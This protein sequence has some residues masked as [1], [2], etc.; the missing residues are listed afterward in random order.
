MDFKEAIIKELKKHVK[1]AEIIINAP[2]EPSMG[3]FAFPCFSLAKEMKKSPVEIAAELKEKIKMP[4]GISEVKAN[5]PY[6]NFFVK[7]EE[8]AKDVIHE[9]LK[10]KD[11]YGASK[12]KKGRVMVEFFHANTHK[13]VHIG[14]IRNISLGES[15]CRIMELN[16]YKVIRANY[17]GDIGPHV[18]KCLWGLRNSRK[19]APAGDKMSFL[20]KV[21]MEANR[22]ISG[23]EK[24]EQEIKEMTKKLYEGDKGLRAEWK[25]TREWCLREFDEFY[26]EYGVRFDRSYF[27][28]EVERD[29]L[30]VANE[31]M[32]KKIAKLDDSAII[33]DLNKEGLGIVVLV[34][35]E[36]YALYHAKDLA[37]A[38][39]KL[40][41][42][43]KLDKSI[44]V[45]GKE[46]E[47]YFKQI[48][49]IFEMMGIAKKLNSYHLIY[50]L[51]MLPEGK[52]SSREGNVILYPELKNKLIEKSTEEVKKRHSDWANSKVEESAENIAFGALKF[53][54][55]TREN[56][57]AVLFD[58]D[59]AMDFEGDTGPYVQYA[60][61]RICS[62]LRKYGKKANL[63]ADLSYLGEKEEMA[64]IKII[65]EFP[66][67]VDEA[68]SS[69]KPH[70]VAYY[71]LSLSQ[72]F[73]E[74][75]HN[76]QILK[77]DATFRD[78]R[79]VLITAVRHVI[80]NGL[81]LLG[82]KA[83]EEM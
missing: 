27:E 13:G 12:S 4:D 16:G 40:K 47:L 80:E 83:P 37:L 28:S 81:R 78:A 6:L 66:K 33:I 79:L 11:K 24:L 39:R 8:L 45:V 56:N 52:M 19:K 44:H 38:S 25:K 72:T 35:K 46:Q 2:P 32:K 73:N 54:M 57:K 63:N 43:K 5:G 60:H 21:Y 53:G 77:E 10:H 15:L 18:V 41:E 76:R 50:E 36:G 68:A 14:H 59:K 55:L 42:F 23:N 64:L 62:I 22:Q 71:L 82:I 9:V 74:F 70:L 49:R 69:Y 65:S 1:L 3:D 51:V 17:Q 20:G 7:K 48:F 29:G 30:K 61:A 26:K 67:V 75:Y 31:L 58:W 34:T